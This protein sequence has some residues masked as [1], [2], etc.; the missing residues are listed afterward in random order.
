MA[1]KTWSNEEKEIVRKHWGSGKPISQWMHEL[2]GRSFDGIATQGSKVLKLGPRPTKPKMTFA[3]GWFCIQELLSDNKSRTIAEIA[4]A[5]GFSNWNV[6]SH[7]NHR[8]GTEVYVCEW[9]YHNHHHTAKFRL[10][11][12]KRSAPAPTP[13]TKREINRRQYMR[14]KHFQP[15]QYEEMR[16]KK[17]VKRMAA[18]VEAKTAD[19]AASW[20]FNPC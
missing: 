11:A 2:P 9:T 3:H 12:N 16:R 7:M 18:K 20:M 4:E 5:T 6:R 13:L 8:L 15:E 19:F 10:G 1:Y 14:V 17:N